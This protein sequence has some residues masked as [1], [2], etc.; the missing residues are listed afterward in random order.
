MII[1]C[2]I[3]S[4]PQVPPPPPLTNRLQRKIQFHRTHTHT[5]TSADGVRFNWPPSKPE[6]LDQFGAAL[7]VYDVITVR[8]SSDSTYTSRGWQRL[9]G[10]RGHSRVRGW[11]CGKGLRRKR[12]SM[13]SPEL[14][15]CCT[16]AY[17]YICMCVC[18]SVSMSMCVCVC[19]CEFRVG[20]KEHMIYVRTLYI[21]PGER[22]T[23]TTSW[24][25][26]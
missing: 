2:H 14:I 19:E 26:R 13:T 5:L 3:I 20:G 23:S 8:Y 12:E 25:Y 24:T 15:D 17:A 7:R 22:R 18:M 21:P 4:F 10:A 11:E 9:R 6:I 1:I 16:C